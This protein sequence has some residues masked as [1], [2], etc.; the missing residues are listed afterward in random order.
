[1]GPV[2]SNADLR[3][4]NRGGAGSAHSFAQWSKALG[5]SVEV[6]ECQYAGRG[7]RIKEKLLT[8]ASA[9]ADELSAALEPWLKERA[10]PPAFFGFSFGGILAYEVASRL[11][12]KFIEPIGLYICSAESP[13][14]GGRCTALH[15]ELEPW[16]HVCNG[17]LV[18]SGD[19]CAR[20]E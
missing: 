10:V 17:L 5:P 7:P 14:W 8:D 15:T 2:L 16:N 3:T 6:V 12:D 9:A 13:D 18:Q 19:I 20:D 11:N 4:G 1:M